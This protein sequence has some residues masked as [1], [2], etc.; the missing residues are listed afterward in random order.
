MFIVFKRNK[1]FLSNI[2]VMTRFASSIKETIDD[3]GN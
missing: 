3:L 1:V 2:M